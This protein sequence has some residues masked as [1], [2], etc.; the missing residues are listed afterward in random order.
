MK[1]VLS[2]DFIASIDR[3]QNVLVKIPLQINKNKRIPS[4][5]GGF[6]SI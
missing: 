5:A 3:F 6:Q 4:L 2:V 1:T